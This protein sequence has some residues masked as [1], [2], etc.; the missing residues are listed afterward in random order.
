MPVHVEEQAAAGLRGAPGVEQ[1]R[2]GQ[3]FGEVA[4]ALDAEGTG[5]ELDVAQ[6]TEDTGGP[7][8]HLAQHQVH[9]GG[10]AGQGIAVELFDVQLGLSGEAKAVLQNDGAAGQQAGPE[11]PHP[12]GVVQGQGQQQN[13]LFAHPDAGEGVVHVG[14]DAAEGMGGPFGAAQ[15][16]RW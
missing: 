10:D 2:V 1:L 8:L 13:I 11:N 14:G 15:W 5:A 7:V 16:C 9:G 4:L 3:Q 12:E 6:L